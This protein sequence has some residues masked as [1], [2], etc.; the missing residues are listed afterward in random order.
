LGL[1]APAGLLLVGAVGSARGCR[2]AV[3]S[4]AMLCG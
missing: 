3:G 4:D 2:G 1:A